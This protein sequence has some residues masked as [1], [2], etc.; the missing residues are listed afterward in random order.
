METLI[1]DVLLNIIPKMLPSKESA[2]SNTQAILNP[3]AIAST[4]F[5]TMPLPTNS[6]KLPQ[7]G[8][9]SGV[10]IPFQF[11]V[12]T[13][14][15]AAD[16]HT[17]YLLTENENIKSILQYYRDAT[18]VELCLVAF[19]GNE[20]YDHPVTLDFVW[21]PSYKIIVDSHLSTVG[22]VRTVIG[23]DSTAQA[24]TLPCDLNHIN[25]VIKSPIKYDDTPRLNSR[26][27]KSTMH[28]QGERTVTL[29]LRGSVRVSNPT[30]Y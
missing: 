11:D 19:P 22:G 28:K 9:Q 17:S 12:D 20:A 2:N 16:S 15:V 8:N 24:Y 6:S 29:V 1:S 26:C 13:L 18:L 21:T 14:N 10:I 7:T 23:K 3:P 30:T 4:P 27:F 25:P 5:P